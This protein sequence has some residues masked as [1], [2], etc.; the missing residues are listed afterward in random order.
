MILDTIWPTIVTLCKHHPEILIFLSLAIGYYVGK[1]KF[2]GFNLGSTASVLL[3]ALVLGQLNVSITPLI[4]TVAFALFIFT[5]GYKVGP[6][7][8]GGLRKDGIHYIFLSVFVAIVG[9]ITAVILG[10]LFFYSLR[11][12]VFYTHK[13][14][15]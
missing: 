9:L 7:F 11:Y 6:Q 5:I 1:I 15:Y 4:K 13:T 12:R 8:F 10:K 3:G 14:L 2:F